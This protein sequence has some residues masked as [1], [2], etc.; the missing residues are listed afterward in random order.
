MELRFLAQVV[1]GAQTVK[2][3]TD[4]IWDKPPAWWV[5]AFFVMLGIV[6]GV[7][8]VYLMRH[9]GKLEDDLEEATEDRVKLASSSSLVISEVKK[10][11]DD[12]KTEMREMRFQITDLKTMVNKIW[13]HLLKGGDE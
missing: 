8:I 4:S 10:G 7:F 12:N 9:S 11:L 2:N 5:V 3:L 6:T 13:E 1:G